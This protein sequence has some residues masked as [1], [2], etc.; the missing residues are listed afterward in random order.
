LK[1]GRRAFCGTALSE[2]QQRH[3]YPE[4]SLLHSS[5]QRE[6]HIPVYFFKR[7]N[8]WFNLHWMGTMSLF[9]HM[10]KQGQGR[11]TQWSVSHTPHLI[12]LYLC[13]GF[14]LDF[15]SCSLY[16]FDIFLL[17]QHERG[18]FRLNEYRQHRMISSIVL[19]VCFKCFKCTFNFKRLAAEHEGVVTCEHMLSI[20]L[21]SFKHYF[22]LLFQYLCQ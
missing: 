22:K 8:L 5:Q 11:L 15:R 6:G 16:P 20:Y 4:I 9:L 1:T 7:F 14:C 3:S 13:L 19:V 18:C 17:N 12:P 10:V 2:K 21:T